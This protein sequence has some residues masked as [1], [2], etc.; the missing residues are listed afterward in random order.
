M[1]CRFWDEA[2]MLGVKEQLREG[3]AS[4]RQGPTRR[5]AQNS[6]VE[7]AIRHQTAHAV[8]RR[9]EHVEAV[10]SPAA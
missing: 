2:L 9:N 10:R 3:P 8:V 5:F 6:G 7:H 4:V 1:F